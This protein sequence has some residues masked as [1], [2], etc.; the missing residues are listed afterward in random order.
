LTYPNGDL[1]E[2]NFL[3]NKKHGEGK[4]IYKNKNILTGIWVKNR[5][6]G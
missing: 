2:G 3:E 6:H 4:L 1:F 5:I